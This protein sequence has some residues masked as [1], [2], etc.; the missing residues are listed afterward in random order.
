[1]K[2]QGNIIIAVVVLLLLWSGCGRIKYFIVAMKWGSK[3]K[4][5]PPL[6]QKIE[7]VR[8]CG[9]AK[10][11]TGRYQHPSWQ[12]IAAKASRPLL[13]VLTAPGRLM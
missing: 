13:M 9:L 8:S 12:A 10:Y 3:V 11:K 2:D 4:S 7:V 1:V 5:D 6:T